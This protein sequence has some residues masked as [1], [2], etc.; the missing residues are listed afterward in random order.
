MSNDAHEQY[1]ANRRNWDE[2]AGVHVASTGYDLDR[3]RSSSDELSDVVRF[4]RRFLGDL[5]GQRAVHLQCH[6]GTDT[7][8][9]ARLGA[10][11]VGFDQSGESLGHARR[12]F[13]VTGTPGTFVEGRVD[14]A[15]DLLG[16]T[17]D[18]VYTGVGALNWLPSID[19]WASIVAGLLAP[20][21]Q[22]YIREGHPMLWAIDDD[23]S[24]G[25]K[26]TYPY[27]ET[28]EPLVFDEDTTYVEHDE[29]IVNTRTY[30]WNHG[31]GEIFT[32]LTR[33]GL[34]V[35]LLEE[36]RG[37]EWKMFDHMVAEDGQWKLP[38]EQRD[39]VP[40]MYSLMATKPA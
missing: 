18:L 5:S 24:D 21:G 11:V 29:P 38:P 2:R 3:L 15:V 34:V 4:D 25:L 39:L 20:G 40:L 6:I 36:H 31:L 22:L 13:E 19:R 17:F 32:A 12:L 14:D 16:T 27:F 33:H 28:V 10:E 35:T 1:E 9:L 37:L 26:I 8:S 30:E 23:A 7:L